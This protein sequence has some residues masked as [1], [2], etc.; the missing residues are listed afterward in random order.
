MIKMFELWLK[1]YFELWLK[2]FWEQ[3]FTK[4][5]G[6]ALSQAESRQADHSDSGLADLTK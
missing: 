1:Q 4:K 2:C 3:I 6:P 5:T